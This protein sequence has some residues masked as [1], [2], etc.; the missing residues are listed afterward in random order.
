LDGTTTYYGWGYSNYLVG[1]LLFDYGC[2]LKYYSSHNFWSKQ[3]RFVYSNSV[4]HKQ[5]LQYNFK[6]LFTGQDNNRSSNNIF[7]QKLKYWQNKRQLCRRNTTQNN[8]YS[9]LA[10]TEQTQIVLEAKAA[11]TRTYAP[12]SNSSRNRS[13][14]PSRSSSSSSSSGRSSGGSSRQVGVKT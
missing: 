3:K 14:S 11:P 4:S 9:T 2:I 12:A 5:R 6:N 13:Y 10:E 7:R 8:N 1:I